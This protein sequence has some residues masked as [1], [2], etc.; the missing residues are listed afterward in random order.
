MKKYTWKKYNNASYRISPDIF[1]SKE[2]QDLPLKEQRIRLY[3]SEKAMRMNGSLLRREKRDKIMR[4]KWEKKEKEKEENDR[5]RKER[6][7]TIIA[8][9][10]DNYTLEQIGE[11]IG[12]SRERI[13]QL[14]KVM[15]LL[16]R[17]K[18][19]KKGMIYAERVEKKCQNKKCRKL[20]TLIPSHADRKFCSK[21]CWFDFLP[22]GPKRMTHEQFKVY[23]NQ[24]MKAYYRKYLK[25]TPAF[26]EKT[27][28]RNKRYQAKN[29][30]RL[31]DY[32]REYYASRPR[33][34][35]TKEQN[36]HFYLN[37]K[38]KHGQ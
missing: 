38:Q 9:R 16:P 5:I 12:V 30:E 19:R 6:G 2:F 25:G 14:E 4:E 8:L 1:F 28:E 11:I 3:G 27:R 37:R 32:R 31:R 21:K 17:G 18:G 7:D 15:G 33:K 22:L 34:K 20:M 29:K 23:N 26:K 10:E 24:R 13:R 35:R 36:H